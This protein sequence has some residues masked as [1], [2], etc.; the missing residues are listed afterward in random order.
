MKKGGNK[1][2]ECILPEQSPEFECPFTLKQLCGVAPTA[3]RAKDQNFH[4]TIYSSQPHGVH[5]QLTIVVLQPQGFFSRTDLERSP[6]GSGVSS[7]L[8]GGC[9]PIATNNDS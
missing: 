1:V 8:L 4:S 9:L 6:L 7:L 5:E 2:T 3:S